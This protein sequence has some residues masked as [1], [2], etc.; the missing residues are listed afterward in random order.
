MSSTLP[1][2]SRLHPQR[3]RPEVITHDRAL[4][5]PLTVEAPDKVIIAFDLIIGPSDGEIERGIGVNFLNA[6]TTVFT[7]GKRLN[8]EI[9][10]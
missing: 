7:L 4:A 3:G 1:A 2:A 10:V 8:G 5:T 9:A 6:G